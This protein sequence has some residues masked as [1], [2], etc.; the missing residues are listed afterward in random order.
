MGCGCI[1]SGCGIWSFG[2]SDFASWGSRLLFGYGLGIR[3]SPGWVGAVWRLVAASR[4]RWRGPA[5]GHSSLRTGV[6]CRTRDQSV[7]GL[8]GVLFGGWWLRAGG[9]GVARQ[10]DTLRFGRGWFAGL[11]T[12]VSPGWAGCCLAVGGCEP[13]AMGCP[14]RGTLFA[15][16]RGALPDRGSECPRAW[17][18]EVWRPS[19]NRPNPGRVS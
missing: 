3:V 12:R 10:G 13:V 6:V 9:V 14:G 8:G 19:A 4:W 5:G 2:G 11:G 18:G 7:P 15:S 16:D 1:G 17:R